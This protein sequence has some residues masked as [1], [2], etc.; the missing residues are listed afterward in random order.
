MNYVCPICGELLTKEERCYRCTNN[1]SYDIARQGYVNL[2]VVQQKHSLNPGDTRQQVLA[3]REF[4]STGAYSPIVQAL[5]TAAKN[6]KAAGPILDIGCGEGYYCTQLADAIGAELTG[7]DISKEAVRCAAGKYKDAD[8]LCATAS[9]LPLQDQSVGIITSLF[10]LTMEKEFH[11][12]LKPAGLYFQILAAED[13]LLGLKRII[14][15][16]LKMKEKDTVPALEGFELLESIPICFQF[17]V[18]GNMVQNLLSMTPH[19][20]RISKE[21]AQ[22]LSETHELTDTASC[23][24]NVYRAI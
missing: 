4:L 8:W 23:I 5:I 7:I 13:H 17:T 9:H 21:G 18:E 11:R 19:A 16:E 14:Y 22:R 15:P 6:H 24:L 1:H 3:R 20:H 2:L 12:V 10:A